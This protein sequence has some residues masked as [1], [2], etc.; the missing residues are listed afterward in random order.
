MHRDC[1]IV[2]EIYADTECAVAKPSGIQR[3]FATDSMK[4][5][6]KTLK[7]LLSPVIPY[8]SASYSEEY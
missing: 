5:V 7:I 6:R 3:G 8:Y 1:V 4:Y 2:Y